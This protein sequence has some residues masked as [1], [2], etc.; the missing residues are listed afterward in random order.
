MNRTLFA[1]SHTRFH[2]DVTVETSKLS[3]M[4]A[5]A[6]IGQ[7][8]CVVHLSQSLTRDAPLTTIDESGGRLLL[9]C[10]RKLLKK[11]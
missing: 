4:L 7:H 10:L 9:S 6:F 1:E 2:F 5:T 11:H 3:L 8:G